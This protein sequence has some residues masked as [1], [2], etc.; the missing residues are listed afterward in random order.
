MHNIQDY[1]DDVFKIIKNCSREIILQGLST[2]SDIEINQKTSAS[3]IATKDDREI[4]RKLREALYRVFPTAVIIGEESVHDKPELLKK[5]EDSSL[6]IIIDP[7]DGTWHYAHGS[8][9]VGVMLSILQNGECILGVI[10]DPL[11]DEFIYGVKGEGAYVITKNNITHRVAIT[12]SLPNIGLCSPFHF[13]DIN[14]RT[15]IS[16]W[17]NNFDRVFSL[18]CS[19][20][21]YKMILNGGASF[22]LTHESPK[23]WDH[24][25][26]VLIINE[27]GG[28]AAKIDNTEY[29]LSDRENNL[30]VCSSKIHWQ[31]IVSKLP[32]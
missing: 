24:L 3:D 1:I 29:K 26:G 30:L 18:S 32:I 5:A 17:M 15:S 13:K 9:L 2:T 22:Y 20:F 6:A 12:N 8:N 21:E 27:A 28:Y 23:P 4:E 14:T 16:K 19:S 31:K 11:N 7:I 25:A 10:Y